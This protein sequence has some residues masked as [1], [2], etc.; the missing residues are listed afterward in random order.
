MKTNKIYTIA[1]TAMHHEGDFEFQLKL[2]DEIINHTKV[3][4]IKL[5]I[6]L[7]LNEY[8][9]PDHP[10]YETCKKWIFSKDN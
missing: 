10:G 4:F 8:F 7:D 2:I 6:L 9:Y 1:E 5:H 3:D